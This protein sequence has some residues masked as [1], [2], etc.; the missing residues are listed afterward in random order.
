MATN[1]E[2]PYPLPPS[3]ADVFEWDWSRWCDREGVSFAVG[4]ISLVPGPGMTRLGTPQV[5]GSVVQAT[6][7]MGDVSL[8]YRTYVDCVLTLGDRVVP[9]RLEFVA[10]PR[11]DK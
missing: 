4:D 7:K 9:R 11:G 3:G 10:A 8:G 1:I 2:Q 6:L 5:A